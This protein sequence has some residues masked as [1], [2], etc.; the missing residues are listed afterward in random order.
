MEIFGFSF[1]LEM[2]IYAELSWVKK[3]ARGNFFTFSCL[4]DKLG[5]DCLSN[6]SKTY[7]EKVFAK[8]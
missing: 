3:L 4:L 5:V 2:E 1:N 6:N 8:F 7:L